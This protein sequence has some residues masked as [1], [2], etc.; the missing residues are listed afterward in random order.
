MLVRNKAESIFKQIETI[1]DWNAQHGGVYV[2]ITKETQPNPYLIDSLRDISTESGLNLTKLNPA[3]MTR[4]IAEIN[5]INNNLKLHLTSLKPIRPANKADKWETKAL[6]TFEKKTNSMLEL[7]ES[8]DISQYRYMAPLVV[9]K[10]CMQC[11]AIQGYQVG[12]IRGG[13]SISFNS[14]VYSNSIDNGMLT[15][16]LIHLFILLGG[17]IFILIYHKMGKI[18]LLAIQNKNVELENKGVILR[19]TAEDLTNLNAKKDKYF[20][21]ISHDLRNPFQ[22][23]ISLSELLIEDQVQEDKFE[24][25]NLLIQLNKTSVQTFQLLENLLKWSLAEMGKTSFTP[26]NIDLSE[27]AKENIQLSEIS[28]S[29]KKIKIISNVKKSFLINAD[30]NLINTIFRNLITN[31]IKFSY[32]GENIE[33]SI[34]DDKDFV[35][36]TIQDYGVGMTKTQ[37]DNLFDI[38]ESKSTLGTNKE[39]GTGLGLILC[40]EFVKKHNGKIWAESENNKGSK[41]IFT[42]PYSHNKN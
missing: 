22:T 2:P 37:I 30:R 24:F 25:N 26:E 34:D 8:G 23:L 31:A 27:I 20:S 28:A 3:Y 21:I 5:N 38:A 18:H 33:V 9:T 15:M 12:D 7:V 35:T 17:I 4:Q 39:K 11:H 41:F 6:K 14:S 19:K 36:V 40:A 29:Q 10:P 13:L 42:I 32:A 1:R 16:F